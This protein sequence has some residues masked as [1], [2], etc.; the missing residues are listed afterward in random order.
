MSSNLVRTIFLAFI[1]FLIISGIF[2]L[3]TSP[4]KPEVISLSDL[5]SQVNQ[6]NIKKI[7][8]NDN[9][10]KIDFKNDRAQTKAIKESDIS[11]A[12]SLEKYGADPNKI[13]TIN[14]DISEP[15]NWGVWLS[16]IMPLTLPFILIGLILW[17][18]TRFNKKGPMEA[19]S[20]G[21]SKIKMQDP[22]DT[23]NRT[24]FDDVA[25][26]R[27]AKEELKEVVDFLKKPEKFNALGALI[28]RGILLTGPAGVGKTLLAKAIAGEAGVPFF[29]ISGSEF[30]EMFVGVGASRVRHAFQTARK[31]APAILFIDELDAIGRHRGSGIGG[32]HDEREQTL[33]QILVEM[34]GFEPKSAVIVLAATN[35]PD[36]LDSALLRPGRFDR[37][38][39]LDKPD[40]EDREAILKIH[41]R[42]KPMGRNVDVTDIA[43]RTVGFSGADLAN[44]INEAA[45]LAVKHD[46]KTIGQ[47]ELRESIEKVMLGP[48]RKS[49]ILSR[50][51]KEITAYH[52]AAHALVASHLP[53]SDPVQKISIIS[54]GMAAGYTLK[55]P[56]SDKYLHTKTEFLSDLATLLAGRQAEELIFNTLTTGGANDIKEATNL[57]RRLVTRYGMSDKLGPLT[58]GDQEDLAFLSK[59]LHEERNYS[60]Q[61]AKLI[62]E[63][64][65][66]FI[67]E[68]AATAKKILQDK[69]QKLEHIANV[70]IKKETIEKEEFQK[71]ITE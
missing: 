54:R 58:Y 39:V 26:L 6:D 55:M 64:V 56:D 38:A 35:R 22:K 16:Y 11:L 50:R 51:E 62:D 45:I 59:D 19:F 21:Q 24:T 40:I 27:E 70:L 15:K 4:K 20:F 23:K 68:A 57:A 25:G 1:I 31:N 3:F 10:L 48:E 44:L 37:Q 28:P 30:V 66:K 5:V 67:S 17:G 69:R 49:H 12:E 14:F 9:E 46:R 42:K 34:D 43:R 52:E 61:T 18:L 13:K 33:N 65:K 53:E 32:G 8:V 7:T 2:T 60:D 71:I 41:I 36:V 47:K 29:Y 63:E